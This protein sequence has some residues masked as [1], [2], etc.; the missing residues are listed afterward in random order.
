MLAYL[1]SVMNAQGNERKGQVAEMNDNR[2]FRR[3]S[4]MYKYRHCGKQTRETGSSESYVDLCLACYD[5][6]GI[7]NQHQN[8]E[9]EEERDADCPMCKEEQAASEAHK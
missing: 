6:A 8:G 9:H 7:E 3:G 4:G 1:V 5:E 2:R